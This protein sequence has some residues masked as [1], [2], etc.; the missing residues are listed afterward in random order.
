MSNHCLK[1]ELACPEH[2]YKKKISWFTF[3]LNHC[4]PHS[5][6]QLCCIRWN[7]PS[8]PSGIYV[9]SCCISSLLPLQ[10]T[11][12]LTTI[13]LASFQTGLTGQRKLPALVREISTE[14]PKYPSAVRLLISLIPYSKCYSISLLPLNQMVSQVGKAWL[15]PGKCPSALIPML[16]DDAVSIP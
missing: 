6:S 12:C 4:C 10:S 2:S 14:N 9:P 16:K 3:S 1:T 7:F 5:Q 8:L 15:R 13:T 11:S